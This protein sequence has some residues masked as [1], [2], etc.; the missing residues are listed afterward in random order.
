MKN[1]KSTLLK[2]KTS[3]WRIPRVNFQSGRESEIVQAY[4]TKPNSW[5]REGISE[6]TEIYKEMM[7][8]ITRHELGNAKQVLY[9]IALEQRLVHYY[10]ITKR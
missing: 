4:P 1:I 9:T 8:V 5:K 7:R 10:Q 2:L 3:L 6:I